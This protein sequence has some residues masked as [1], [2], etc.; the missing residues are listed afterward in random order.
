MRQVNKNSGL[1][2]Y[3]SSLEGY[4][5]FTDDDLQ[6]QRKIYWRA[7]AKRRMHKRRSIDKRE[8]NI[9]FEKG[10][11]KVLRATAKA[12]GYTLQN[13]IRECLYADANNLVVIPHK[14]V[15]AEIN[16]KLRQCLTALD[17][18]KEKDNKAWF[19]IG[20][21]YEDVVALLSETK[22][23]I[24][25]ALTVPVS[26]KQ[27]IIDGILMNPNTIQLLQTIL[28]DYGNNKINDSLIG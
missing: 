24:S 10:Q 15:L 26:L 19:Q 11:I 17:A 16:Q 14:L 22:T 6:I 3:L 4:E 23:D 13:Y 5:N 25:K 8:I 27:T 2:A 21:T 18:I 9:S 7:Y 28:K 20:S 1:W 12:K